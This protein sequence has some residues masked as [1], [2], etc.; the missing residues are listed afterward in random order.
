MVMVFTLVDAAQQW[1]TEN[2]AGRDDNEIND[3][4]DQVGA[5]D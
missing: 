4:L 1:L 3:Q 2:M 5:A